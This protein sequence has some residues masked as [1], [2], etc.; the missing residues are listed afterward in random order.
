MLVSLYGRGATNDAKAAYG[1]SP[2]ATDAG[3]Q[4]FERM[5][6][7]VK[8][9]IADGGMPYNDAALAQT[10]E[11][12]GIQ[13]PAEELTPPETRGSPSGWAEIPQQEGPQPTEVEELD[14]RSDQSRDETDRKTETVPAQ[15]LIERAKNAKSMDELDEIELLSKGRATVLEAVNA[16]EAELSAKR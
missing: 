3:W 11:Y 10:T 16:R 2:G 13:T 14:P 7:P 5:M 4:A 15:E 8:Q 9:F 1:A 6:T 12:A